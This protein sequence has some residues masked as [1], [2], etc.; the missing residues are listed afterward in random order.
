MKLKG[1]DVRDMLIAVAVGAGT[2][3]VAVV[4]L[5]RVIAP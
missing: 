1:K 4:V 3:V 5:V 2:A